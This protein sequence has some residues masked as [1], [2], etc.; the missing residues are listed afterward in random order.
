M[1]KASVVKKGSRARVISVYFD[2]E[3]HEQVKERARKKD[4]S[5]SQL[6]RWLAREDVQKAELMTA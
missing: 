5:V 4:M 6:L 1:P 3:L 2:D